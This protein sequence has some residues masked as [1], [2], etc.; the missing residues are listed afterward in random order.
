VTWT[1]LPEFTLE[2]I[3]AEVF[4][5]YA[6]AGRPL[7][8]RGAALAWP[9]VGSWT[10]QSLRAKFGRQV[11]NR[12]LEEGEAMFDLNGMWVGVGDGTRPDGLDDGQPGGLADRFHVSWLVRNA[13]ASQ[14]LKEDYR[15]FPFLPPASDN[16]VL[17]GPEFVFMAMQ[18]A[19]GREPHV[20][21]SCN[22]VWS[23]QLAGTKRW[24]FLDPTIGAVSR[25]LERHSSSRSAHAHTRAPTHP[26]ASAKG[27]SPPPPPG[28]T[29]L[30][31]EATLLP[32][33]VVFWYP[34]WTH[35]TTAAT[36]SSVALS[37]EFKEPAPVDYI[38][39]H[40]H[41]LQEHTNVFDSWGMCSW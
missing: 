20:D 35:G 4:A 33:D 7:V 32:G 17:Q 41:L 39:R 18:R 37:V 6:R 12:Q 38:S 23:A 8:V 27:P 31:F 5:G 30:G 36:A 40:R 14:M 10:L 26:H 21:F 1:Q 11:S 15:P 25:H 24:R 29:P 19:E 3:T 2:T 16:A 28:E 22:N 13:T 34:G 9:A